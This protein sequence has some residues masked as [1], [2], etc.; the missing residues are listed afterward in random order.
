MNPCEPLTIFGL[1]LLCFTVNA[2]EE[3]QKRNLQIVLQGESHI[4]RKEK[5]G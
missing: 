5:Y 1:L 3:T 4:K 2:I